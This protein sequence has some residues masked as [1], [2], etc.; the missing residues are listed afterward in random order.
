MSRR[1]IPSLKRFFDENPLTNKEKGFIL[2]CMRCQIQ[3][4]QLTIPQWIVIK[5]IEQKYMKETNV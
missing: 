3:Y 1:I 4:P 5:E 2:S